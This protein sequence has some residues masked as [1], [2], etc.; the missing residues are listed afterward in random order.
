[1]SDMS[2]IK[3]PAREIARRVKAGEIAPAAVVEAHLAAIELHNPRLNAVVTP[4]AEQALDR[5]RALERRLAAGEP[6]GPLAG[7]PVGVKDTHPTRGV[8]TTYGSPLMKDHVPDADALIVERMLAAD[9]IMIGK[10]NT[11]EFAYGANTTNPVFGATRNP[12]NPALTSA[13]STG[14]GAAGL[15]AGMFALATGSDLGGSL[16][17]P[18]AFCGTVGLRPSAGLVP[19]VP[20]P[21]PWW[22]LSVDGPMARNVADVALMLQ[23]IAGP[24][25]LEPHVVPIE[26]R[27]FLAAATA[28][29][30]PGLRVAYCPDIARIGVDPEVERVCRE[31]AFRLR[32]LGCS[33]E[34]VDLD[35]SVGRKAFARL[36]GQFVLNGGLEMLDKIDR[37]GPNYAG[38]L[39]FALA[40][41]P[42]DVAEGERGRTEIL[43]RMAAFFERYDRLLTPCAPVAPFPVEQPYPETIAGRKLES[44][45]DW[46][47]PTFVVSL[48]GLPAMSVPAG[49]DRSNLPVGLQVVAPRW[50]EEGALNLAAALERVAPLPE[51][52]LSA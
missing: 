41:S 19:L 13:G 36:R 2:I 26:G 48:T 10:T 15:V 3:L 17:L 42:R 50:N 16:R 27:D 30:R 51:P 40:Q 14:G 9:A 24:H 11:P 45:I 1:M 47:A 43:V 31:A 21:Q 37:L 20:S 23:A 8:R 34:E 22:P 4:T 44:Y 29:L 12:W 39:R 7:V 6:V 32:D 38:N 33:V 25:P 18:A 46:A 52:P 5:A 28:P 49:L 35:L